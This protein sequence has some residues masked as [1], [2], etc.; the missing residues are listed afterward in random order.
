MKYLILFFITFLLF[1]NLYSQ[2]DIKDTVDL[3][4]TYKKNIE[5]YTPARE[6]LPILEVITDKFNLD[7]TL[8]CYDFISWNKNDTC[9][10][11]I[12]TARKGINNCTVYGTFNVYN[13]KFYCYGDKSYNLLSKIG[14]ETILVSCDESDESEID[15]TID[16]TPCH[17]FETVVEINA[18]NYY[19]LYY[20]WYNFSEKDFEMLKLIFK[21][22]FKI[23]PFAPS[24]FPLGH[25][26][27]IIKRSF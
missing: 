7:S 27:D 26:E 14:T 5:K 9:Y 15:Y 12:F 1:F 18:V 11:D 4:Y 23:I 13:Q 2:I 3:V 24:S 16:D 22:N 20:Q 19:I 10:I 21:D 25:L 6:I 17:I 8:Y